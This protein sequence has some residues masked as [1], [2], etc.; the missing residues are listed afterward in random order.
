MG[1]ATARA[2]FQN[3]LSNAP[4]APF[5]E[6]AEGLIQL[7]RAIEDDLRNLKRELDDVRSKVNSPR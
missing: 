6:L 4:D 5:R 7:S 2:K 1:Y 3:V